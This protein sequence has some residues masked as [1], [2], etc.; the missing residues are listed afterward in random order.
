[1][2]RRMIE[3]LVLKALMH[4]SFHV[5]ALALLIP[6]VAAAITKTELEVAQYYKNQVKIG[7]RWIA[8]LEHPNRLPPRGGISIRDSITHQ[9]VLLIRTMDDAVAFYQWPHRVFGR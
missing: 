6:T 8:K 1:M 5:K 3:Q 7:G 9:Q 2:N 4:P